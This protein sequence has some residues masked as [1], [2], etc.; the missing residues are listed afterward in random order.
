M[1][2]NALKLLSGYLWPGNVRELKNLIERLAIMVPEDVI[3]ASGIPAPY[4]PGAPKGMAP[5]EAHFLS[6]KNLKAAKK[7]FEKEFIQK[8]LIR[9]KNNVAKT[10]EIIGV[11][12]SYLHK[13]LKSLK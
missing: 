6:I 8:M 11:D 7:A 1:S 9:N 4:N 10:A 3:E 13:K 5:S 2:N 12:R